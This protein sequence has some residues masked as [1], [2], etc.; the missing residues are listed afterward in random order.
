VISAG[1]A[2]LTPATQN[3]AGDGT[4]RSSRARAE[5]GSKREDR[6]YPLEK[7]AN[8]VV[9][10]DCH[11]WDRSARYPGRRPAERTGNRNGPDQI[12]EEAQCH[13]P[14]ASA[15]P[16]S[17][18]PPAWAPPAW[19][20]S[21]RSRRPGTTAAAPKGST[22]RTHPRRAPRLRQHT[23]PRPRYHD[24]PCS[25]TRLALQAGPQACVD[26][27]WRRGSKGLQRGRFLALRVRPARVAPRRQARN[28]GTEL[29]VRWLLVK[30]PAGKGALG[31]DHFEGRGWG[32]LALS[33]GPGVGRARVPDLGAAPP[34]SGRVGLTLWQLLGELQVL[35][36]CWAGACPVCKRP[37]PRWLRRTGRLPAP[38]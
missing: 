37:A 10:D 38:T 20:A 34:R 1:P 17:W 21:T 6:A 24:R 29:P 8:L 9:G 16:P 15:T 19:S 12:G 14:A 35:L 33:R 5:V 28:S 36:A 27:I 31:L 26:L 25:L 18:A 32:G 11:P 23:A 4:E 7:R 3:L 30:W 13:L 22:W 2:S